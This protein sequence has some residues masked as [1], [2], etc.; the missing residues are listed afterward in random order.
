MRTSDVYTYILKLKIYGYNYKFRL[1]VVE[2]A[3]INEK[4]IIVMLVLC[5]KYLLEFSPSERCERLS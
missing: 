3:D 1:A 2:F 5:K 4:Y